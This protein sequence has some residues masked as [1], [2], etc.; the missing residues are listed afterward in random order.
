MSPTFLPAPSIVMRALA[1]MFAS[2][3]LAACSS[4]PSESN[5]RD[6]LNVYVKSMGGSKASIAS[7][8]AGD[9]ASGGSSPGYTCVVTYQ[10]DL[11][12]GTPLMNATATW[13]FSKTSAGWTAT[14]AGM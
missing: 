4:G 14:P 7:L 1:V 13:R 10:L 9:C 11:G 5:M 3:L 12:N 6:A 8:N 2:L